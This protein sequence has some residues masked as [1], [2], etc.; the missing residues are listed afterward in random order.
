ME[1][2]W[3]CSYGLKPETMLLAQGSN[4]QSQ[5]H[6]LLVE[7]SRYCWDENEK[8]NK[9]MRMKLLGLKKKIL[10]LLHLQLT[11]YSLPEFIIFW[12]LWNL[13]KTIIIFVRCY[14]INRHEINKYSTI[15]L[16]AVLES[17][18]LVFSLMHCCAK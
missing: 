9:K 11:V 18:V 10:K 14:L 5:A 1:D 12:R 16:A 6:S 13:W 8:Q 4:S 2:K 7:L 3:A 17:S 15:T